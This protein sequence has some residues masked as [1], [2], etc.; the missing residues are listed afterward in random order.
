[1]T[2]KAVISFNINKSKYIFPIHIHLIICYN[3]A[4]EANVL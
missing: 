3:Y 2:R 1:M 4:V